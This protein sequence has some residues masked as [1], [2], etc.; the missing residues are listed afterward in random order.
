LLEVSDVTCL[1]C[2]APQLEDS[3]RDK[4]NRSNFYARRDGI[5][6]GRVR[7]FVEMYIRKVS[8]RM[9][10][11]AIIE[12]LTLRV[13]ISVVPLSCPRHVEPA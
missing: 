5:I 11:I 12:L 6:M 7:R 3:K 8:P 2:L 13:V 9:T 4:P 1:N 10:I